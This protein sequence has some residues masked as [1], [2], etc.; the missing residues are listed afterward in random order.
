MQKTKGFTLVEMLIV[1]AIVG[2]LSA[3]FTLSFSTFRNSQ[4]LK[5]SMDSAL[6]LLYEARGDTLAG[7]NN[8]Q[9]SVRFET[10]Q[11][12]FFTGTTY[13]S[14]TSTNRIVAYDTGVSASSISLSGGA[15]A[16][17]FTQISGAAN[18]YGTITLVAQNGATKSITIG[19]SGSVS[20]N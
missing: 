17:S 12:V 1:L 5:N 10:N 3:L 18:P 13:N 15:S 19:V 6:A 4:T 16:V 20:H 9:Y 2:V 8:T 7:L 11:M 14:G